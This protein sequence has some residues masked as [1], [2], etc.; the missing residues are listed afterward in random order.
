MKLQQILKYQKRIK[1]EPQLQAKLNTL[2]RYEE[3]SERIL[4]DGSTP[5][6]AAAHV[7]NMIN[8]IAYQN[9]L[10]IDS[11]SVR[12]TKDL[13]DI[14]GFMEVPIQVRLKCSITQLYNL[15]YKLES[16]PN[17]LSIK[18]MQIRRLQQVKG[19]L[20]YVQLTICGYMNKL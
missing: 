11:L 1:T 7:Q 19:D 12:K 17:L 14:K 18:E 13:E 3:R 15:L 2:T 20:L 10:T 5:A 6:L 16:A 9:E 4:I 8:E